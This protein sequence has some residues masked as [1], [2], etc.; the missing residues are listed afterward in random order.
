MHL[1]DILLLNDEITPSLIKFLLW[2]SFIEENDEIHNIPI[3][4]RDSKEYSFQPK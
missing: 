2:D 3:P 1:F 4:K